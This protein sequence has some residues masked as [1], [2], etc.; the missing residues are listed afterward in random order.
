MCGGRIFPRPSATL[1]FILTIWMGL[2]VLLWVLVMS[3]AWLKVGICN[4]VGIM[5]V[6]LYNGVCEDKSAADSGQCTAWDDSTSWENLDAN[7]G[8]IGYNTDY[9]SGADDMQTVGILAPLCFVFSILTTM[10]YILMMMGYEH[11]PYTTISIRLF[12]VCFAAFTWILGVSA[13]ATAMNSEQIT[14]DW[15]CYRAFYNCNDGNKIQGL[16]GFTSLWIVIIF[17]ALGLIFTVIP[18][19][20]GCSYTCCKCCVLEEDSI[21]KD[22]LNSSSL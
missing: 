6:Q 4:D 5:Y 14:G 22:K 3:T 19:C 18:G 15:D 17:Q 9:A 12:T 8:V 7:C 21:I 13:L 11:A 20:F 1:K 16:T 2:M 10:W